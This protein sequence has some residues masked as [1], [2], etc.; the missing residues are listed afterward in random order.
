MRR[1]PA[2]WQGTFVYMGRMLR[3]AHP[4]TPG[5]AEEVAKTRHLEVRELLAESRDRVARARELLAP[6]TAAQS[7]PTV[8]MSSRKPAATCADTVA[9]VPAIAAV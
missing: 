2:A 1:T 5:S 9:R 8:S 3:P 4:P 6:A 7:R